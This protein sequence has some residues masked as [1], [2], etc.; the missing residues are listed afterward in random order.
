MF[1]E[2]LDGYGSYINKGTF[3]KFGDVGLKTLFGLK[4]GGTSQIT[5]YIQ[6]HCREAFQVESSVQ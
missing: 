5:K 1:H 3:G 4:G 2:A 6:D